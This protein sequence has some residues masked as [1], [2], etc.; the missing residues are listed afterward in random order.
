MQTCKQ[1]QTDS[2]TVSREASVWS[3][4][5]PQVARVRFDNVVTVVD[6]SAFV[7]TFQSNDVVEDRPDLAD[8][9]GSGEDRHVVR[10]ADMRVQWVLGLLTIMVSM[11]FGGARVVVGSPW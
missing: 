7:T 1:L 2:A 8:G 6:S 3:A 5:D 9:E 10:S 11:V 4:Q